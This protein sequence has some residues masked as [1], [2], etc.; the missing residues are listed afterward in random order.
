MKVKW[1]I[2]ASV[3]LTTISSGYALCPGVPFTNMI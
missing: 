2:Y 3:N 1:R